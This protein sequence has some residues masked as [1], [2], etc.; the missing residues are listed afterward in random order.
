MIDTRKP[1]EF[2]SAVKQAWIPFRYLGTTSTG[3]IVGERYVNGDVVLGHYECD[4]V[5]LRNKPEPKRRPLNEAELMA[6]VGNKIINDDAVHLVTDYSYLAVR[7]NG[8]WVGREELANSV[9][10]RLDGT[11]LWVEE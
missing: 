11:G 10:R 9:C 6:L 2:F 5:V 4:A 1:I 3:R 7:I 8:I